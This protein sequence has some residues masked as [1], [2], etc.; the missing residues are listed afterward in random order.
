MGYI[1]KGLFS[2]GFHVWIVFSF[3]LFLGGRGV[4]GEEGTHFG[5]IYIRKFPLFQAILHRFW[6]IEFVR[7]WNTKL[8]K[9]V[10]I[11]IALISRE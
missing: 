5:K 7:N 6:R 8:F 11:S 9:G 2:E 4:V 3:S 10:V 1:W